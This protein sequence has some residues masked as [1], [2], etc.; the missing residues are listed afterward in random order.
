MFLIPVAYIA[1][2]TSI[3]LSVYTYAQRTFSDQR[4]NLIG[5]VAGSG[6]V[7]YFSLPFISML[8]GDYGVALTV[9]VIMGIVFYENTVGFF[10]LAKGKYTT[11]QSIK[12]MLLLPAIYAFVL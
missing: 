8:Y 10:L 9:L 4:K 2:A 1:L 6:N 5:F 12:K 11:K 7:G 3:A